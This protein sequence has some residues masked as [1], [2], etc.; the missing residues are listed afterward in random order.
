[1]RGL[2]S[3]TTQIH[4]N[5]TVQDREMPPFTSPEV[6]P[7]FSLTGLSPTQA[8][9]LNYQENY[10]YRYERLVFDG[11]T[12]S[13][14]HQSNQCGGRQLATVVT[15]DS[16]RFSRNDL[17][18]I[19]RSRNDEIITTIYN[20]FITTDKP[21]EHRQSNRRRRSFDIDVTDHV[22]NHLDSNTIDFEVISFGSRRVGN[23]GRVK[24][25]YKPFSEFVKA[26]GGK[27]IKVHADFFSSY[28]PELRVCNLDVTVEFLNKDGTYNGN[29]SLGSNGRNVKIKNPFRISRK[30]NNF[31][32]K[33]SAINI[34]YDPSCHVHVRRR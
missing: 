22:K 33:S 4:E 19:D 32:F 31:V 1:M 29:V 27:K 13:Q 15:R 2:S 8:F 17:L 20:A 18:V 11:L 5:A 24:N 12:P 16:N 21:W 28:Y 14:F 30:L 25:V 9:G 34:G 6:N 3:A 7:F 23:S 10:C 26:E